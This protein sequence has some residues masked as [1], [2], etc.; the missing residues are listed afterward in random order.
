MIDARHIAGGAK[1]MPISE[2]LTRVLVIELRRCGLQVYSQ[3]DQ[4]PAGFAGLRVGGRIPMLEVVMVTPGAAIAE[5]GEGGCDARDV[6]GSHTAGGAATATDASLVMAAGAGRAHD[7]D[8]PRYIGSRWEDVELARGSMVIWSVPWSMPRDWTAEKGE[9]MRW[10]ASCI[11]TA[12]RQLMRGSR[13]VTAAEVADRPQ[14][15]P[16]VDDPQVPS[17]HRLHL[18]HHLDVRVRTPHAV[19]VERALSLMVRDLMAAVVPEIV[20]EAERVGLRSIPDPP[21][22]NQTQR[23]E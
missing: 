18:R 20:A 14:L 10:T 2:W 17:E 8:L 5:R 11:P 16:D 4:P 9:P 1:K 22:A 13:L 21:M 23:R 3:A 19:E 6:S 12:G 7:G 15:D